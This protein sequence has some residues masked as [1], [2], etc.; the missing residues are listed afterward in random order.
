M[1]DWTDARVLAMRAALGE[2][3]GA[4][5]NEDGRDEIGTARIHLHTG[6][7]RSAHIGTAR[8]DLQGAHRSAHIGTAR[9]DLHTSYKVL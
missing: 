8:I 5:G 9:I 1:M 6:A 3:P 2:D 4:P 7:H